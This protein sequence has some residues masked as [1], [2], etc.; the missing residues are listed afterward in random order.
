M[1]K[2]CFNLLLEVYGANTNTISPYVDQYKGIIKPELVYAVIAAESSFNPNAESNKDAKGLMQ[3]TPIA[4]QEVRNR[5][6]IKM[7]E[8]NRT[9]FKEEFVRQ[10]RL[11]HGMSRTDPEYNIQ[12]G[13]C[14]LALLQ[15]Q[16]TSLEEVIV[17]YHGGGR[18]VENL[19][20]SGELHKDTAQYLK[21][22]K[23]ILSNY[24]KKDCQK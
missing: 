24:T 6:E 11:P 12:A 23:A 17:A 4:I 9:R 1:L 7:Y 22:I 10:C 8:K 2:F 18:Q 19:R 15:K 14:Y 20:N 16:Y 3:L 21:N 5:W 13:S